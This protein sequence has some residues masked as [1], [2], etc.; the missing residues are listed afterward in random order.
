[1][2]KHFE[3]D[4]GWPELDF[5]SHMDFGPPLMVESIHSLREAG[6][7]RMTMTFRGNHDNRR[8][9]VCDVR[10]MRGVQPTA[11]WRRK[12][13]RHRAAVVEAVYAEMR[14]MFVSPDLVFEDFVATVEVNVVAG[15]VRVSD[16]R[17]LKPSFPF[18]GWKR[19]LTLR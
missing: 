15:A 2:I 16:V 14:E 1:M 3:S 12:A 8:G 9:D 6:V 18:E 17:F 10:P 5:S 4:D 13:L 11:R 19:R 7:A